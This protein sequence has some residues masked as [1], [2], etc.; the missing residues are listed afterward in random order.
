MLPIIRALNILL[1]SIGI[2]ATVYPIYHLGRSSLAYIAA[3][4]A[5]L[6][7]DTPWREEILDPYLSTGRVLLVPRGDN[8]RREVPNLFDVKARE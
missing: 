1:V 8:D 2:Q 4:P 5:P 6:Q 7:P 3:A